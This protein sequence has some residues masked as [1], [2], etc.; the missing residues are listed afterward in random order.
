MNRLVSLLPLMLALGCTTR[1]ILGVDD[2]GASTGARNTGAGAASTSGGVTSTGQSAGTAGDNTGTASGGVSTS[3]TTVTGTT[4]GYV[5][6]AGPCHPFGSNCASN[7]ECCTGACYATC[8]QPAG[9][10]CLMPSDCTSY[11]CTNDV[12]ACGEGYCATGA[13]CCGGIS[14]TLYFDL[15]PGIQVGYCCNEVGGACQGPADCCDGNCVNG[16]CQCLATAGGCRNDNDCCSGICASQQG[17]EGGGTACRNGPG[18]ACQGPYDCDTAN[19]VD[20]GCGICT[21][22]EGPC[23][24]TADCCSGLVCSTYF[25]NPSA[26]WCC[27]PG[28]AP[29]D[30]NCCSGACTDGVCV[31]STGGCGNS[32]ACCA[33][34]ACLKS[35][36]DS[37]ACCQTNGQFCLSDDECCS[38]NCKNQ[39]CACVA[40]GAA[41]GLPGVV[42][43][44]GA[45]A[46]CSSQC[47]DG[48][49]CL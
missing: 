24:A 44:L 12:C 17:G 20:G 9:Q 41:C 18:E 4:G 49:E 48:G 3:G 29:C 11:V 30:G 13:D 43:P 42:A 6:D 10:P 47:G 1:V 28:G 40:A 19:C 14:C 21:G 37:V 26:Q 45:E 5:G 36:P 35:G 34:G 46:C 15:F 2:G 23:S 31:C 33:G 25:S 8:G 27:A 38:R 32:Q 39:Q 22:P 7:S 16:T